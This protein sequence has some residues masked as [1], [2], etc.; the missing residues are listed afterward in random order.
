MILRNQFSLKPSTQ[1][2][3]LGTNKKYPLALSVFS[4]WKGCWSPPPSSSTEVE[5]YWC[6]LQ[7]RWQYDKQ[8]VFIGP[9]SDH[10]LLISLTH[11]QSSLLKLEWSDP[12]V[13]A[14]SDFC[15]GVHL[16][17]YY[18]YMCSE[19][20]FT[21]EKSFSSNCKNSQLI[22]TAAAA[23]SQNSQIAV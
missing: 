8:Y 16:T 10:S 2:W 17:V 13:S 18:D 3:P 14:F 20:D 4:V 23:L 9:K 7:P 1:K 12:L 21:P 5:S 19:M 11:S 6:T 15:F 22:L